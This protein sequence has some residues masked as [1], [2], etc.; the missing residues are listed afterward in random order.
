MLAQ[1]GFGLG[2]VFAPEA[3]QAFGGLAQGLTS[4]LF[5]KYGRDDERQADSLGV[6]YALRIDHDPREMIG[7]FETLGRVSAAAGAGA[8]PQWA[9]THPAPENRAQLIQSEIAELGVPLQGLIIGTEGYVSRLEGVTFG[10]DVRQG[11]FID[12]RFYHPDLAFVVDFPAGWLT[13]NTRQQVAAMAPKKNALV[14]LT[15]ADRD[16]PEAAGE[17]FYQ[18]EGIAAKGNWQKVS[19]GFRGI[20]RPFGITN[21]Q[22]TEVIEGTAHFVQDGERVYQLLGYGKAGG[23]EIRW[24]AIQQSLS[25]MRRLT[26]RKIL[27]VQPMRIELVTLEKPLATSDLARLGA[28][29]SAETL[30][31]INRLDPDATIPAGS[32][33]K[34][35]KGFNPENGL[36]Q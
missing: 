23:A 30:L 31:L 2:A 24:P 17:A 18:Q 19:R 9:S 26:D 29:V 28:D 16:T 25:S 4:L 7:V 20:A 1:I 32:T 35:V 34:V 11:F 10:A 3:A 12:Q 6:R 5:L 14:A 36:P 8:T 33:I 22:G 13:T 15:L 27:G 21:Q